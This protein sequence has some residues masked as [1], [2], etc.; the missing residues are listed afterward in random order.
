LT[1]ERIISDCVVARIVQEMSPLI[2]IVG[3]GFYDFFPLAAA[4]RAGN[5]PWRQDSHYLAP[6]NVALIL[7]E[8]QVNQIVCVGKSRS[9]KLL[10]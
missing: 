4:P 9:G 6:G 1:D 3:P 7:Y 2:D 10:D 8:Y 5:A